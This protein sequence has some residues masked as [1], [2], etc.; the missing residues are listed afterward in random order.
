MRRQFRMLPPEPIADGLEYQS[1]SLL[2]Y[3]VQMVE[4]WV[5][6]VQGRSVGSRG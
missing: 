1:P 6:C 4:I 5:G 3:C 2:E